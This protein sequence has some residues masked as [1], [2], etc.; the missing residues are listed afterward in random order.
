MESPQYMGVLKEPSQTISSPLLVT[1]SSSRCHHNSVDQVQVSMTLRM[2]FSKCVDHMED[3]DMSDKLKDSH[4]KDPTK[5]TLIFYNVQLSRDGQIE[6]L[7]AITETGLDFSRFIRTSVRTNTSPLLRRFPPLIYSTLA[8]EA[9]VAMEDFVRWI[10]MRHVMTTNGDTNMDNVVLLAH[11]GMHRDH[12]YLIKTLLSHGV[13][14]PHVRFADSM[15]L[16]KFFKRVEMG[17]NLSALVV[18]YACWLGHVPHDADSESRV[19]RSVV[20]NEFRDPETICMLISAPHA[21]FMG[22]T[23]LDMYV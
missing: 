20:L 18:K 11:S 19:L 12:V 15:A 2:G 7:G 22:R 16:F 5:V 17:T 14:P 21:Q 10:K 8:S 1:C 23:G 6:Q 3:A 4:R 9:K 13:K